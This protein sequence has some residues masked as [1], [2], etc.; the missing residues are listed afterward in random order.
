M[1]QLTTEEMHMTLHQRQEMIRMQSTASF[2]DDS[3]SHWHIMVN[4]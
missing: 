3:V 2:E 1:L 4:K